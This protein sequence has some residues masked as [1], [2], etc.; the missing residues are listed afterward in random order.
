MPGKC[1]PNTDEM[2]NWYRLERRDQ[3]CHS[4]C[5]KPTL[6]RSALGT[7]STRNTGC[8]KCQAYWMERYILLV[9]KIPNNKLP[10]KI[11]GHEIT[12]ANGISKD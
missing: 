2:S 7:T 8:P 5:T 11:W 6:E 9:Q 4:Y 3:T 10:G 12:K 1:T